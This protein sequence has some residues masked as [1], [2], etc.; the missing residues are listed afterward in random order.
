MSYFAFSSGTT[1]LNTGQ[2]IVAHPLVTANSLVFVTGV[3]TGLNAGTLGVTVTGGS[4]TVKSVNLSDN[5]NINYLI[6][7]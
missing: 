5:R 3:D 7:G 1:V 6:L 2:V 4:F